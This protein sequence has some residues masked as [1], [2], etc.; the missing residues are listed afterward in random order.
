MSSYQQARCKEWWLTARLPRETNP[1]RGNT[2]CGSKE[3]GHL[4]R[5]PAFLQFLLQVTS[6][7]W[8]QPSPTKSP[9]NGGYPERPR[10]VREKE[11]ANWH[12][13]LAAAQTHGTG[14]FQ[15]FSNWPKVGMFSRLIRVSNHVQLASLGSRRVL[16]HPACEPPSGAEQQPGDCASRKTDSPLGCMLPVTWGC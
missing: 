3:S 14:L 6:A 5:F 8:W 12:Y 13:L 11:T 7:F 16:N 10:P 9:A 15:N 1:R 2:V 4:E